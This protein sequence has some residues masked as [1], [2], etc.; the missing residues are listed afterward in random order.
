MRW[1]LGHVRGISPEVERV[2]LV[3]GHGEPVTAITGGLCAGYYCI[4]VRYGTLSWDTSNLQ[5][6]E[7][8]GSAGLLA[9]S[10]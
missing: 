2:V 8:Y 4:E 6:D 1:V 3:A 10:C 9:S 7:A 5:R